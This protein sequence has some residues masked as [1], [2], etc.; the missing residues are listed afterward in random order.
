MS[1]TVSK[2]DRQGVRT[3]SSLERKYLDVLNGTVSS[4]GGADSVQLSRVNQTLAQFMAFMLGT[5]D[6]LEKYVEGSIERHSFSGVPTLENEPAVNWTTDEMKAKHVGDIYYDTETGRTYRFTETLGVY[7]WEYTFNQNIDSLLD[8]KV[9]KGDVTG[10]LNVEK[11]VIHLTGN[12]IIID[13]ENFHLSEDGKITA[14]DGTFSGYFEC[15]GTDANE[16]LQSVKI[17][18]GVIKLLTGTDN[19]ATLSGES[20]NFW[21]AHNSTFAYMILQRE[22]GITLNEG[23]INVPNGTISGKL[24]KSSDNYVMESILANSFWGMC[25]PGGAGTEWIRTTQNGLIPYSNGVGSLGTSTWRFNYVY[26]VYGNFSGAVNTGALNVSGDASVNGSVWATPG[27]GNAYIGFYG[28]KSQVYFYGVPSS[29]TSTTV[30]GMSDNTYGAMMTY[31]NADVL[32]IYPQVY[33]RDNIR[34]INEGLIQGNNTG[35]TAY[36]LLK[37]S[38]SNT[39]NLGN[40]TYTTRLYGKNVYLNGTS[41]AVTSDERVKKDFTTLDR[42]L[43]FFKKLKPLAFKYLA[44]TSDRFHLGFKAQDIKKALEECGM[45]TQDFAGYV[46]DD[47]DREFYTETIGE[48]KGRE[49]FGDAWD[50]G[51]EAALRYEEFIPLN[52]FATLILFEVFKEEI[53]TWK[54]QSS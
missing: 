31:T 7:S 40:T 39:V 18:D 2:Q 28:G 53:E 48:E 34:L 9:N 54:N 24:V 30:W 32:H 52:I 35:G 25:A 33:F 22:N 13:S 23:G 17:E 42:Y 12:R 3:A 5:M 15:T 8:S 38:D 1:T 29:S 36:T 37:I 16:T 46:E 45:T 14:V 19:Y 44:G 43:E 41:T 10:Q 47:I 4:G 11:E 6:D 50:K 21:S 51:K 20:W 49:I 26:G 27:T